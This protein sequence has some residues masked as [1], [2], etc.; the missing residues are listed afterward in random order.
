MLTPRPARWGYNGRM[1]CGDFGLWIGAALAIGG[2]TLGAL[3]GVGGVLYRRRAR[4]EARGVLL[5][6]REAREV[7]AGIVGLTRSRR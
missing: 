7:L 5:A 6:A 3:C 4:E 2:A 1:A